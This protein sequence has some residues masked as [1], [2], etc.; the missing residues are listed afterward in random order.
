MNKTKTPFFNKLQ[1]P[2]A[3]LL[4]ILLSL[5]SVTLVSHAESDTKIQ[6]SAKT[7]E[8][9]KGSFLQSKNIKPL[10]RPFKSAGHFVYF[11]TKGLLWQTE[12]PVKSIKLFANEGVYKVDQHGALQKEAQLDN[13]FFLA[14]FAA[15]E[16]KLAQFFITQPITNDDAT[17]TCLALTPKS[18]TMKSLFAQIQ[19]C[20]KAM[21]NNVK[22]P[23]TIALLEEKGNRTDINFQLSDK[24][25]TAQE[26]AYFD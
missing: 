22:L 7:I 25:L 13:A 2:T 23:V 8:P 26:L 3:K 14:L 15:D 19:L 24:P 4:F 17:L 18:D 16:Q 12:K 21:N 6:N 1:L 5:S 11:P 10:K 20:T 9:L